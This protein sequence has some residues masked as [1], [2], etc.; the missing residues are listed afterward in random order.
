MLAKSHVG[1]TS[2]ST[3]DLLLML[4]GCREML[5][6]VQNW[7][8]SLSAFRLMGCPVLLFVRPY[9][10]E[11]PD[12]RLLIQSTLI[13]S[14]YFRRYVS[15]TFFQQVKIA[16]SVFSAVPVGGYV[17]LRHRGWFP[18]FTGLLYRQALIL[19]PPNHSMQ[20]TF[21]SVLRLATPSLG[22]R[23]RPLISTL[24]GV[25]RVSSIR[26]LIKC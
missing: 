4:D 14:L 22:L 16:L 6:Q 1:M 19:V 23:Q 21:D 3:K 7:F 17:G 5:G 25:D 9:F 2:T 13:R 26:A 8:R 18:T 10:V 12:D 15:A 24:G 20:R 11:R